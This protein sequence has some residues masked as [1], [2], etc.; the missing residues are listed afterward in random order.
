MC[1][2]SIM[3]AEAG[4]GLPL[5]LAWEGAII[6]CMQ[7]ATQLYVYVRPLGEQSAPLLRERER[8]A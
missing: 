2:A 6:M 7:G 4:A 8:L 5:P 1:F 3:Q